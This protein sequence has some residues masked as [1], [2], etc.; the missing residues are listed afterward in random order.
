MHS[1][2]NAKAMARILRQS[3]ANQ[4]L[5]LSHSACLEIVAYQFG[6]SDWNTLS[7][8]VQAAT[9]KDKAYVMA[10]DWFSAGNSEYYRM[11]LD[12]TSP[13]TAVI[14]CVIERKSGLNVKAA[15]ISTMMQSISAASYRN[16]KIQLTAHIRAEDADTGTI[17][18]RVDK[19]AGSSLRFDNMMQR[20]TDGAITGTTGWLERK[21]IL[22]VPE[23]AESIHY[24]FFLKGYGKV[25][26]RKFKLEIAADD[27][28]TTEL[29]SIVDKQYILNQPANLDFSVVKRTLSNHGRQQRPQS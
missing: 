13:G 19:E 18:L 26:A 9:P 5:H 21:I 27:T 6:F 4:N 11:G 10:D 28:E 29:G 1:F 8:L 24:G 25:W 7:A 22:D 23:E 15:G 3:L 17:W 20:T 14:E 12:H 16:D 2:L